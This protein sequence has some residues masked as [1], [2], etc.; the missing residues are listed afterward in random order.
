MHTQRWD[1]AC[2]TLVII[3][4]IIIILLLLLLLCCGVEECDCARRRGFLLTYDMFF[5]RAVLGMRKQPR[6]LHMA[7]CGWLCL[8]PKREVLVLLIPEQPSI[9][10]LCC[11]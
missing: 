7:T 1:S 4:I 11:S 10:T 6:G 9:S 3:I 5:S 2:V 8:Q